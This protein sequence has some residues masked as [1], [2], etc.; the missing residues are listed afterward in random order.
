MFKR[1]SHGCWIYGLDRTLDL[2]LNFPASP[3]AYLIQDKPN[4]IAD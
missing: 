1:L 2:D 3:G 4:R